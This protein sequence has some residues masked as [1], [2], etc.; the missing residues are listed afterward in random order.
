MGSDAL[1]YVAK[2]HGTIVNLAAVL[3]LLGS[4]FQ[5]SDQVV[6]LQL[7]SSSSSQA[8]SAAMPSSLAK[9][10]SCSSSQLAGGLKLVCRGLP[11]TEVFN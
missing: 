10:C 6:L 8:C 4:S 5:V 2:I 1:R 7:D 11:G 9:R 3:V